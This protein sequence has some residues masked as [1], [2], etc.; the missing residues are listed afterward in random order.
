L[1][2]R[3]VIIAALLVALCPAVLCAQ[4]SSTTDA[5]TFF[6]TRPKELGVF[7][8]GGVG[9]E[10]NSDTKLFSLG[11]HAGLVLTPPVGPGLLRGQFEYGVELIPLWQAYT[12]RV[13]STVCGLSCTTTIGGGTFTGFSIVPANFR[14]NFTSGKKFVP[15]MQ[16]AGGVIYTTHKFPSP[17]SDTSVWNFSPQFGIGTH[18]FLKPHRSLDFSANA[19]HISSASLGDKNPGI[20]ASVQFTVGYTWWK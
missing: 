15:W 13:D 20:N 4:Q 11:A 18:Y 5:K 1:R 6:A 12:P 19:V 9:T 3:I 8:E 14:W 10:Q 16:G 7:A 17:P 2:S